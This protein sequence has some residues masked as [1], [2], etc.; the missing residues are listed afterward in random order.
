[1]LVLGGAVFAALAQVF[2]RKLVNTEATSAIV[3]YFSLTATIL[4]L[5]TLPFGWVWPTATEATL[6]VGAG[7][8][9][10][11][12]QILLTSSYRE[13]DAS[14]VAPFD[15]ASMLFALGIGY[16]VFAEVPTWTMIGG[17]ALI[18]MAG[19]LIIWR[20]RKL[21]LERARQRKAMTP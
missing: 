6:L 5:V 12:G 17:A 11:I 18:V 8:L 13:A 4:S 7:L 9:G 15:Y 2:V 1:M 16:F 21:G 20:E 3:F 19:I 10:G 14:L